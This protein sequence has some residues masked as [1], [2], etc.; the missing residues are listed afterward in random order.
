VKLDAL[1]RAL[2][3]DAGI[4]DEPMLFRRLDHV[5]ARSRTRL[6]PERIAALEA[7]VGPPTLELALELLDARFPSTA[8]PSA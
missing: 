4:V 3:A 6:G 2:A 1:H 8:S 5:L 7:E